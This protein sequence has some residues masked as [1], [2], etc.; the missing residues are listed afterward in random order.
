M[1]EQLSHDSLFSETT[2]KLGKMHG[3]ILKAVHRMDA[4]RWITTILRPGISTS[5]FTAFGKEVG[6][7]EIHWWV[8]SQEALLDEL[9]QQ[10]GEALKAAQILKD[11]SDKLKNKEADSYDTLLVSLKEFAEKNK[12]EIGVL[13]EYVTWLEGRNDLAPCILF[14]Y[15]V[16]GSTRMSDRDLKFEVGTDG[17]LSEPIV[18]ALTETALGVRRRG[19]LVYQDVYNELGFEI[20]ENLDPEQMDGNAEIVVPESRV[21]RRTSH[22]AYD[23]CAVYFAEIR[24]SLRNILWI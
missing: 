16:W 9:E 3:S 5:N 8:F 11:S 12:T 23:N 1:L 19:G 7:D 6:L 10:S 2:L 21:V 22:A 15:R 4:A 24:D 20:Y 14:T 17:T 18:K 13:C